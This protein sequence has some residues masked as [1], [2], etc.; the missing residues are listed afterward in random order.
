MYYQ[1]MKRN[2]MAQWTNL[3]WNNSFVNWT[4][5]PLLCEKSGVILLV[6]VGL[7][8]GRQAGSR[9]SDEIRENLKSSTDRIVGNFMAFYEGTVLL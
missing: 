8:A 3:H 4:Q 9:Q 6:L 7:T 2:S 1:W 5:F